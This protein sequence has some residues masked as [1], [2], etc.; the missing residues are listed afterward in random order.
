MGRFKLSK[1]ENNK[2]KKEKEY[3]KLKSRNRSLSCELESFIF[4][5]VFY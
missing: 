3:H 2:M 4:Y 5:P 1:I